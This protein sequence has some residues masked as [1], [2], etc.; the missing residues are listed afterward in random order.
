M[1]TF[2]IFLIVIIFVFIICDIDLWNKYKK[3]QDYVYDLKRENRKLSDALKKYDRKRD[4][5]GRYIKK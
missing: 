3:L 5:K 1:E 2:C 4:E